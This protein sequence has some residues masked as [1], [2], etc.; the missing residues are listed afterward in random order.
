[1]DGRRS[2]RSEAPTSAATA[3]VEAVRPDLRLIATD[4]DGT[5]LGLDSSVSPRNAAALEAAAGAG[6]EVVV[7]TGRSHHSAVPLVR[8]IRGLRWLLCSNG[9][10]V[11]DLAED[12]VVHQRLLDGAHGAAA[13]AAVEERFPTVGFGWESPTGLFYTEQWLR[14][15]R[16]HDPRYSVAG[17]RI[18][19]RR[20]QDDPLLKVM[21]LHDELVSLDLLRA[22]RPVV[23]AEVYVAKSGATFIEMT[24]PDAH[25]GAA[26]AELC[27][28][29][30]VD[31][32][33]T[34]AFG[35]QHNDL[36]ML[37][38]VGVGYAMA[39]AGPEAAAVA[40]LRAPH[41][42]DDGVGQVVEALLEG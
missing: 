31:R 28:Q 19:N 3:T 35:D 7:A 25:K 22:V 18:V 34:V 26:L 17:E 37:R 13:V 24:A 11:Y 42:A 29:L 9:A 30:G 21:V 10:T 38:W 20:P 14:N 41:H 23:P 39:N 8:H 16:A 5:L 33:S 36:T 32:A 6:V 40:E 15:R 27:R 12:R 4:L 2:G 1:M